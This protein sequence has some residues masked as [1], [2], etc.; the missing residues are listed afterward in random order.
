MKVRGFK[1]V[2]PLALVWSAPTMALD[3]DVDWKTRANRGSI[4][5]EAEPNRLR[6][7]SGN[8]QLEAE[9]KSDRLRLE[10]GQAISDR[11]EREIRRAIDEN[12][13]TFNDKDVASHM[14]TIDPQSPA[15]EQT[16]ALSVEL[17]SRFDLEAIAETV[18]ILDVTDD[19]ARVRVVQVTRELNNDP[20]FR[21]NR[22]S[23]VHVLRKT[24]GEWKFYLAEIESV[25][26]F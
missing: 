26:Y 22:I 11:D 1:L 23:V 10:I 25:D 5:L 2:L 16:E 18:D 12:L 14:A 20:G 7:E 17:F 6:L 13:R 3:V 4:R 8:L 15:Y 24:A 19:T 9:A 21:D